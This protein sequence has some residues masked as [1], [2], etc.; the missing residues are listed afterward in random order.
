MSTLKGHT[1]KLPAPMNSRIAQWLFS[2]A[3]TKKKRWAKSLIWMSV[4]DRVGSPKHVSDLG[5]KSML[6]AL[7]EAEAFFREVREKPNTYL[8]GALICL[9]APTSSARAIRTHPDFSQFAEDVGFVRAWQ[10]HGWP[11][12]IQPNPGTDGSN[13][14]FT[15]S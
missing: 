14:Q 12:Q 2:L 3:T 5:F 9:W 4:K 13:L 7:G 1:D 11:P 8:S 15:C 6:I 10:T